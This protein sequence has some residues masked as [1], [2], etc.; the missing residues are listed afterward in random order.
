[1]AAP[2]DT[3]SLES[4]ISKSFKL[5]PPKPYLAQQQGLKARRHLQDANLAAE[6]LYLAAL[7]RKIEKRLP[8]ADRK[9][10]TVTLVAPET[11]PQIHLTETQIGAA[12]MPS[13]SSSTMIWRGKRRVTKPY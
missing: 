9:L 6:L 12:F 5:I 2:P 8:T 4:R 10:A 11:E 1:M 7:V 3:E 13:V